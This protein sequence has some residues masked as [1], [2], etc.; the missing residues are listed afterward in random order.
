MKASSEL[1]LPAEN[2]MELSRPGGA[3][4]RTRQTTSVC[5]FPFT[6]S[7]IG[8]A[9]DGKG[10]PPTPV[11]EHAPVGG[12]IC[13]CPPR[14]APHN[15]LLSFHLGLLPPSIYLSTHSSIPLFLHLPIDSSMF[16]LSSVFPIP[17]LPSIC[18]S[19][20]ASMHPCI[21]P[22]LTHHVH[23]IPHPISGIL[24]ARNWG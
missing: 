9:R 1:P 5:C 11:R 15:R 19:V 2:Q 16:S 24:C 18:R 13:L 7:V 6:S 14:P 20:H 8:G 23:H 10:V 4:S 12:L 21:H 3:T 17:L 22:S